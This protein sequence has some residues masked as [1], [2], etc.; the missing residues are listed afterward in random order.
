MQSNELTNPVAVTHILFWNEATDGF[1]DLND[2]ATPAAFTLRAEDV[3]FSSYQSKK[4]KGYH[5]W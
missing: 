5:E 2:T 3:T 4:V 1:S